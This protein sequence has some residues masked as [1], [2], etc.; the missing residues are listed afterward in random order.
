MAKEVSTHFFIY[1]F[2]KIKI[3]F[4]SVLLSCPQAIEKICYPL[5]PSDQAKG[6][7][8][9]SQRCFQK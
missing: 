4:S 8:E 3:K 1:A 9:L 6:F 2:K 7:R 5:S